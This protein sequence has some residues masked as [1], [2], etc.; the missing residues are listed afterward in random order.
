MNTIKHWILAGVVASGILLVPLTTRTRMG[1]MATVIMAATEGDTR[2]DATA[3]ITATMVTGRLSG[4]L[5]NCGWR[6]RLLSV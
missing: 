4:R 2:R 1:R 6:A 3:A 5:L